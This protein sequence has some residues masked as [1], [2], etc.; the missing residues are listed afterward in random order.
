MVALGLLDFLLHRVERL[1]VGRVHLLLGALRTREHVVE[2]R[3][4]LDERGRDRLGDV[5][6]ARDE[7]NEL[8]ELCT[9]VG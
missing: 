7:A 5:G 9:C 8:V 4:D 2:R 3:E 6:L 1:G